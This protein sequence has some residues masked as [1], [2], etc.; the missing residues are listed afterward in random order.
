MRKRITKNLLATVALCTALSAEAYD[1]E[2]GGIYYN[3]TSET[4]KTV[5]V[6]SGSYAGD[7]KIPSTVNNGGKTYTVTSIGDDAFYWCNILTSI[8]IPDGVTSIGNNAF[9]M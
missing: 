3:I 2:A 8:T 7:I 5:E 4:D 1:F 6:T 9:S